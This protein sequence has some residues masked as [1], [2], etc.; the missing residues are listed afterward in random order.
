MFSI[1]EEGV[2][3]ANPEYQ[4][5]LRENIKEFIQSRKVARLEDLCVE[6]DLSTKEAVEKIKSLENSG[7]I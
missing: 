1:V 6:F 5:K 7:S 2:D 3:K 4:E